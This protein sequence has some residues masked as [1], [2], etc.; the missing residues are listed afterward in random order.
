MAKGKKVSSKICSLLLLLVSLFIQLTLSPFVLFS[1]PT[2]A[3]KRQVQSHQQSHPLPNHHDHQKETTSSRIT[4]SIS[5][6]NHNH[7]Y[8]KDSTSSSSLPTMVNPR[9]SNHYVTNRELWVEELTAEIKELKARLNLQKGAKH[10]KKLL[11]NQS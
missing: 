4:S 2:E 7:Y 10:S 8:K 5:N 3:A 6:V 1:P 11:Q 9:V